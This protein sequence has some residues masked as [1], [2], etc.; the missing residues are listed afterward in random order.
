[1]FFIEEPLFFV[2]K[3]EEKIQKEISIVYKRL[4]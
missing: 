4:K 3:S 1:M 2:T